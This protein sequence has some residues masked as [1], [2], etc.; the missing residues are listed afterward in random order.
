MQRSGAVFKRLPAFLGAFR[1]H[2]AQKSQAELHDI[3][4][5]EGALLRTRELGAAFTKGEL[6]RRCTAFQIR[7][8]RTMR[9]WNLGIKW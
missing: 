3:G 5:A 6:E 7:A 9:L 1:V 4:A 2:Q 8:L